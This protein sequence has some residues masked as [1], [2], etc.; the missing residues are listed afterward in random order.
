MTKLRKCITCEYHKESYGN[1]TCH[2]NPP[3]I[4]PKGI[5]RTF[6]KVNSSDFCRMWEPAWTENETIMKAWKEFEM[7]AKLADND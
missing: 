6:P 1:R 2:L 3:S 7:I 5:E 4:P